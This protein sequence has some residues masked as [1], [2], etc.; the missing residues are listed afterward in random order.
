MLHI[1]NSPYWSFC[2]KENFNQICIVLRKWTAVE[3]KRK[4]VNMKNVV[5]KQEEVKLAC[6]TATRLAQLGERWSAEQKVMG[7]SPSW[8]NTH[9]V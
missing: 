9:G 6:V 1:N 3:L 2:Q 7:S 5:R 8:T 4:S